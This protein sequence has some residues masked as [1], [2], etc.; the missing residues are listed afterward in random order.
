MENLLIFWFHTV[1]DGSLQVSFFDSAA[2][3]RGFYFGAGRRGQTP[4]DRESDDCVSKAAG[5]HSGSARRSAPLGTGAVS[6]EGRIHQSDEFF[7]VLKSVAEFLLCVAV[8]SSALFLL[9]SASPSVSSSESSPELSEDIQGLFSEWDRLSARET[10]SSF[11][12]RSLRKGQSPTLELRSS[13]LSQWKSDALSRLLWSVGS[14]A[15][16]WA[17]GGRESDQNPL[18]RCSATSLSTLLLSTSLSLC[19]P[20][21]IVGSECS[22]LILCSTSTSF[23]PGGPLHVP[24]PDVSAKHGPE[25]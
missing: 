20:A 1:A 3:Q 7:Q 13:C 15:S 22:P 9:A 11:V 25:L 17:W 6:V 8:T 19:L 14:S 18:A 2:R 21:P 5:R 23:C 16:A 10:G 4:A 12:S 24:A